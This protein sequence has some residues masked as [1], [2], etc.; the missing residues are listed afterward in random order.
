MCK[1]PKLIKPNVTMAKPFMRTMFDQKKVKRRMVSI[2]KF[3]KFP[4]SGT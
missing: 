2:G 1:T 3:A 4:R